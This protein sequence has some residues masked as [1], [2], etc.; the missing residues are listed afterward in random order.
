MTI[1]YY[2][3]GKEGGVVNYISMDCLGYDYENVYTH[4]AAL[5]T[6]CSKGLPREALTFKFIALTY[7]TYYDLLITALSH[8]F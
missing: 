4:L 6:K 1:R 2:D 5:Q 3:T 7:I 8:S